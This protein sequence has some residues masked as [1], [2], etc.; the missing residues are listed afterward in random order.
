MVEKAVIGV[1]I[2]TQGS[3]AVLFSESGQC[4]AAAVRRSRLHQP[5]AGVVEEDP[6]HQVRTVCETIRTCVRQSGVSPQSVVAVGIDGQMAGVV[7]IGADGRNVTPYDSWLDTR[8]AA[9][10]ESM[11]R[12]AGDRVL[13]QA[14]CA[15]SFNHGPKILWWKHE[16]RKIYRSIASFVQPGGYAAMRL[17]GLDSRN[18]FIDTTYLHFSGF[19]DNRKSAWDDNLCAV[20]D[21]DRSKLPRIVSPAEIIGDIAPSMARRCNLSAGTPVVAGCGDTAASFLACGATREGI[22]V[23]VAGTASVFAATTSHFRADS[24]HETLGCGQAATPGLWHPYAYINGGGMNLEW[25]RREVANHGRKAGAV[26]LARLNRMA[27]KVS[28]PEAG[29]LFIPHLGGRVCPS[30]PHLRGAWIGLE[31]SHTLGHLYRAVLEGVALE[32]GI[33]RDIFAGLY[34]DLKLREIRVTGGGQ[35]SALWNQIKSAVLAMPV[36]Q[37]ACSEGAPMGAAMLAGVGAGLF[38]DL[39]AVAAKWVRKGTRHRAGAR[40]TRMYR[41]RQKHYKKLLDL[42]NRDWDQQ[43]N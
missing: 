40:M 30:A 38:K 4:L 17:C 42:L 39:P 22:C 3:K 24:K 12:Q 33:Y 32:Y 8:C 28:D 10:I 35:D 36:V 21:V 7:G 5:G 27:E 25:F 34:P 11:Q 43:D 14:G 2:G 29:P 13:D 15:P 31:W 23:D 20:F 1:D 6:E 18:A 41:S 37:I 19:A 26:T 9:Y 16:R